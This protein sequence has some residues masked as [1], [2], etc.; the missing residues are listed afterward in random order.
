MRETGRQYWHPELKLAVYEA[1]RR[2]QSCQLMKPPDPT[3]GDLIQIQPSPPLTRWAIDHTQ[4]G[5]KI[6]LNAVEYA[7]GWLESRWVNSADFTNTVPLLLFIIN[8]F[9]QANGVFKAILT[10]NLLDN[11]QIPL[12]TVLTIAVSIYN[13]RLSPSGYSPYFLLF[14]TQPPDEELAYHQY[15]REAMDHEQKAW[16]EEHARLHAAPIVRSYVNSMKAVR[17]KTRAYLQEKKALLRTYVTGDWVLRVRQRG[18][19]FEPFCDVP[20]AISA[21]HSNNTY[22]LVSPGGYSLSNRYNDTNLFPAY[23]R[24]GHPVNSLWYGSKGMLDLDRQRLKDS[25]GQ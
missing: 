11:P 18:H 19:K 6:L 17:A 9:E 23:V 12:T 13:R 20:W 14:G 10:R 2:C 5:P 16:D 4:I 8:F 3:L 21:C 7:T 25:S 22:S 24:D 15:I 1:I